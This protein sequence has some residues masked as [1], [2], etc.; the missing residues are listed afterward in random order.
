MKVKL[1]KD[2]ILFFIKNYPRIIKKKSNKKHIVVV[3][4]GGNVGNLFRRFDKLYN[5]LKKSS[6]FDLLQTSP[7]F[8]NPPFGYL[9]QPHFFNAIIVLKTNLNPHQVLKQ[10]LR[11]ERKFKRKRD[12]KD[13]PRTLD[14]DIIFYD[15]I[16]LNKNNLIIPHKDFYKRES[17]LLPLSYIVR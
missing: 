15:K 9:N 12:F 8:K 2:R 14:L 7:I 13:S 4:I 17:V 10:L 5:Y 6:N 1:S 11:I 16:Y 3:G